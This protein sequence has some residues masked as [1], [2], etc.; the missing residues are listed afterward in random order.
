MV[1]YL[2]TVIFILTVAITTGS[3]VIT[4]HLR[5]TYKSEVFSALLFF[6]AFYFTF[7]FYAIWGQ[8]IVTSFLSNFVTSV[9][10]E[11]IKDIMVLLGAP[12]LV[13]A[14]LM[15]VRLAREISGRKTSNSFMLW[16]IF[17]NLLIITGLGYTMI[18]YQHINIQLLVKY[19]FLSLT[20]L[21]TLYGV[22]CFHFP[23]K[24]Q[25]KFWY[26]DMIKISVVLVSLM[27]I[28]IITFLLYDYSILIVL[29]FILGYFIYGGFMPVYFKYRADLTKLIL[30][31]STNISFEHFCKKYGI[32]PRETEIVNEI[33]NGLTNQQIA[34]KLFISLQTVK[35]HTHRI[36][37]KTECASRAQLIRIV[38]H[39]T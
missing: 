7:G 12:F 8:L 3:I 38:N 36:Y 13:F 34:D 18:K 30:N 28:Q 27:T 23:K 17:T 1:N 4:S 32:S 11:K 15:F 35:D 21:F 25:M 16:F 2:I 10:L 5:N 33:C 6:L 24:Y 39:G 20:I 14:S 31:S 9:L 37:S 29:L 26:P 19:Y 22:L